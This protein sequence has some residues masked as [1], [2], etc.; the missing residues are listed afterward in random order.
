[1]KFGH[2][3]DERKEYVI[4]TP[5]TPLPWINY[6]GNEDFFGLISNTA[7]GYDFY[8]DAKM[9]RITRFRYN[10]VPED[11]GGRMFYIEDGK[12]RWSPSF[13]PLKT[14]LDKYE[15][16][17][18]LGYS[19]FS[20]E[21]NSLS[22]SLTCFV[23]L[24]ER[25]EVMLLKL[26]NESSEKKEIRTVGAVEWCLWNAWDDFTNFQRNYS[27]GEVEIEDKAIYHKTEYRERRDHYAFFSVNEKVTG[28]DSDR[29]TFLGRFNGWDSPASI[30]DGKMGFSH[31]SGWSPIAALENRFT[32]LPGEE[33]SLVFVLGYIENKE[34][35]KWEKKG[36]I[37]K[38]KAHELQ[39]R[40]GKAEDAERKLDELKAYWNTLLSSFSVSTGEEKFDRM[41]N[42]WNQYQCMV[43]FNMS[44]SASYYESGIGRGMGFRDSCQDLLG[45]VHIIPERA[46]QRIIDIAS[47]QF[48][49]GSTYHQYQPL[50]KKGN[51]DIGGGFNDDP[52][53]LVACTYAYVAETGDW[54]ILDE[55]VPF[56]NDETK[57]KSLLEHLRRSI[58]YTI[59]HKGPHGLPLIGRADW[60]DCLN[61]NCFSSTPGE[62]FQTCSNFES[63]K[64]ESVFIA[65]LFV[66]YAK[67]YVEILSHL[68]LEE[69]KKEI[70]KEISL[71]TETVEGAGWDGEWFIRAYD[72]FS[73]PVGSHSCDDGKIYIEPQGMCVMAGIGKDDGK[74]E[75]ALKSVKKHLDTK[76][77]IVLLQ[78]A[79]KEYHLNLGEVSSYPPG[80][81]ENAGIFCHNNP[82]VSCAEAFLGH[83]DRAFEIYRKICPA[84]LEEISDVHR[85]EPY[86]Y[87]QMVA[88]IDAQNFGEGK[89][90][91][92]TGCAAWTFV[93]ASQFILGITPTLEGMRV[94]PC[95]PKEIGSF[96]AI[97]KIGTTTLHIS[98]K[99]G[100][101]YS[102][103]KNGEV[104]EGEIIPLNGEKDIDVEVIYL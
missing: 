65:G 38:T 2:F 33:K 9:R 79:Y 39:Q 55:M 13:M 60:N 3:D 46:R 30:T 64:A 95:L 74:A 35:E 18:G 85:T 45:F 99:R 96:S 25:A 81:K 63:G 8:K 7:G 5:Y 82:W 40:Y 23:P 47:I 42:I 48:E 34:E 89:N 19:I 67:Q 104:V 77:G 21:K 86:V 91:W 56:N 75:M 49:D 83:G 61:L 57:A 80:Y 37:N 88:G 53:W 32:L 11:N 4:E 66:K 27:T 58:G 78:P 41:V 71:M 29:A 72:A 14:P 76:Y 90:S 44:R 6:L 59:S 102:L 54:S 98:G 87:S 93:N 94:K 69:E 28:Y 62:S 43:T 97:R 12:D 70:E 101:E 51:A 73:E 50:D 92:L 17:H 24:K 52:L 36:V 84:Y 68:G 20:G 26:R 1:M 103:K 22:A 16:R 100:E 10:N 31:A 15:C